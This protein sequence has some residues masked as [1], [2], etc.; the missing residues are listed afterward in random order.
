[1]QRPLFIFN[2]YLGGL[3]LYGLDMQSSY[4]HAQKRVKFGKTC[5]QKGLD[6]FKLYEEMVQI[7]SGDKWENCYRGE[8]KINVKT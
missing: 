3:V 6:K 2:L 4:K 1:M 5:F 7:G 8:K